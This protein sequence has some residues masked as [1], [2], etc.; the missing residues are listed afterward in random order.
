MANDKPG[1]ATADQN[2]EQE[3][4]AKKRKGRSSGQGIWPSALVAIAIALTGIL[5]AFG[6][7]GWRLIEET[8]ETARSDRLRTDS[9]AIAGLINAR[10]A[11]LKKQL[12]VAGR[13]E[14]AANAAAAVD[15][16]ARVAAAATLRGV[17]P[18][19]KRVD[20]IP[21][22][23]AEVDLNADTPITFAA[24]D[25]I[26]RA[27]TAEFVGPEVSLQQRK[28]LYAASPVT[29]GGVVVGVL[30][31]ALADDFFL[32]PLNVT[33]DTSRGLVSLVQQFEGTT[34]APV[35]QWGAGNADAQPVETSLAV[36]HWTLRYQP[37]RS[38][39]TVTGGWTQ[40]FTPLGLAIGLTL[41]G[42]GLAFSNL[43]KRLTS[44]AATLTDYVS[45]LLR[46]RG[47]KPQ[48]YRSGLF[49]TIARELHNEAAQR[50]DIEDV[51]PEPTP[52][53]TPKKARPA[54]KAGSSADAVAELLADDPLDVKDSR[55]DNFGIEVTEEE[56]DDPADPAPRMSFDADI[57][58][59]YDI[60]GIVDK[61]LGEDV[62]Y[63][64]GRSFAAEALAESQTR[65][66]IGRDGRLSSPALAKALARGLTEGGIDVTDIG[67][68]PTPLLYFATHALNTGTGIMI[69][70]SHN[71]PNYNGLKMMIGG[72]TLA[73]ARILRL[74][75]RIETN[76]LSSGQG[77]IDAVD[78]VPAYLDRVLGDVTLAQGLKVVVDCGNGVAGGIA[79]ELLE[80][81][82]CEVV[83]L[84]CE[85]D[86][87]FP[88]HHP[89]PA[90][91]KNLEDLTT[92]VKAEDAD[93]GLAFD[94]DGD[95]LGVV[96]PT[97]TII[98]PD[99]LMMLFSQ[100]IVSR[101]PGADIIYDVKCSRH[102]NALISDYG[103]RPIMWR[104]GHSHIKAKM[105]ETG[106]LLG[107]EFS[108]HICFGERWYGFDD[109]LYS[110]ARLLEIVT[111][112]GGNAEALFAQYPV[113]HATPELKIRT[114]EKDKFK[115]ME[116]L[117]NEADFGDGTLTTIDGLRV[118]YA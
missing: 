23:K 38:L 37:P 43:S 70:G 77:A 104:T 73:E 87:T 58:R 118:D 42:I 13:S 63:W 28:T 47:S 11:E 68:V 57:F 16:S 110:A 95:R 3:R 99:K 15:D 115:I 111:A 14:L 52:P 6:V 48:S 78:I 22:G 72:S 17:L 113:T 27:E 92:V 106:A 44:D 10:I 94:G 25:V 114:T 9:Q 12:S 65:A 54:T 19:A 75:Q 29:R 89:D 5:L 2:A 84:Y 117:A 74:H 24:L 60:R 116:R 39:S 49:T 86:G 56:D 21:R 76:E 41:G 35:L 109:A 8:E 1:T 112:E 88:N 98:W 36:P 96:T 102:L 80:Q 66:V 53:A 79:P 71:P 64:I 83:P 40:L 4:K 103:G 105:K 82:G 50:G 69:T 101:N 33:F 20:I 31:V 93:L 59:A 100:D 34:P 107:G 55:G 108:G 61:N 81:L 51:A 85:V 46:G 26:K 62:V 32:E 18:Y 90:E 45:R 7:T 91:P 97:G 67:M 30:F